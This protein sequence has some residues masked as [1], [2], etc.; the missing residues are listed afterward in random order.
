M[1]QIER[2]PGLFTVPSGQVDW[3]TL[4]PAVDVVWDS[5]SRA[6]G[7]LGDPQV[8]A[9]WQ[10]LGDVA[11]TVGISNQRFAVLTGGTSSQ[12]AIAVVD[13]GVSDCVVEADLAKGPSEPATASCGVAFRVQDANNFLYLSMRVSGAD[14]RI[15]LYKREAGT[16]GSLSAPTGVPTSATGQHLKIVLSG[17]SIRAFVDGVQVINYTSSLFQTAK[18]HGFVMSGTADAEFDNFLVTT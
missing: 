6:D 11:P 4:T 5:F 3:P 12:R 17:T 16:V 8:G 14:Q 2:K 9:S 7:A 13:S 18:K 1:V 15:S 10:V